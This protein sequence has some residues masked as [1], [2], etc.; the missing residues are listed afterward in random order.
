MH[1]SYLLRNSQLDEFEQEQQLATQEGHIE[2]D[3]NM[4]EMLLSMGI[5][6]HHA[7][8]ALVGTKNGGLD[9]VFAYIEEHENDPEFNK[10]FEDGKTAAA[11]AAAEK[12]KKKKRPRVIP[13][14]LQRLFAQ[15]QLSNKLAISTNGER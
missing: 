8:R 12:T 7:K 15:L 1:H 4:L 10:P 13:I 3:E 2:P 11:A 9:G 5:L 6:E 14:E